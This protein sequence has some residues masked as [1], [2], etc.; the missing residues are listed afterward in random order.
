MEAISYISL[1][2]NVY[3]SPNFSK[4]QNS[5][6][7][8]ASFYRG[9]ALC[10]KETEMDYLEGASCFLIAANMFRQAI[11]YMESCYCFND[12]GELFEQT[13]L[14]EKSVKYYEIAANLSLLN[15]DYE[16]AIE[17]LIT[18]YNLIE[19][20]NLS[21]DL[22]RI[23]EKINTNLIE[24]SEYYAGKKQYFMAGTLSLETLRYF[25]KMGLNENS[26][27]VKEVL[28]K[29]SDYYSKEYSINSN[30]GIKNTTVA[31]ILI[32]S[33]ISKI[34][35][36]KYNEAEKQIKKLEKEVNNSEILK[37]YNTIAK[38][39]IKAK[40]N[41]TKFDLSHFNKKVKKIFSNSE[42]IKQFNNFLF[43]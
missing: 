9:A 25:R 14:P 40:K 19:T 35:L 33:I 10:F 3:K 42:E 23:A 36:K 2:K 11:E 29:I 1:A 6:H 17:K 16:F 30:S 24:L 39:M 15:D 13:D 8:M 43:Y 21:Y 32:L 12:A 26:P 20:K 27:E 41:G 7:K 22:E 38:E 28:L 37:A 4:E 34:S 31:Y 18:C 5:I